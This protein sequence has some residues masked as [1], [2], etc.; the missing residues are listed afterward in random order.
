MEC[1][2]IHQRLADSLTLGA[3]HADDPEVRDH[4]EHCVACREE[5]AALERIWAGLDRIPS[6]SPDSAAMRAR[7]ASMLEGYEHGR[8][9]AHASDLAG[10]PSRA[11]RDRVN[12]W[13]ARWWPRQPLVQLA[14]AAALLVLGIAAGRAGRAPA[15]QPAED[16]ASL[17]GELRE[18]RQMLGLSLMQ[19]QSAS[20]R[21]RGVTWSSRLEEPGREVVSA[22]LDTLLHD[23]NVN[24]RLA[25]IDA[26]ARFADEQHVRQGAIDALRTADSPIVQVAL[27]D[28]VVGVREQSSVETLKRLAADPGLHDTVRTRA[29]QGLTR[30][31][32][33]S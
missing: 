30:L 21:L 4:L 1:E 27:I 14:A 29:S 5:A 33:K 23:P 2:Q 18:M 19:Q 13:L 28:F 15:E 7:F 16:L 11:R 8:D 9:G 25:A 31:G 24:V 26:L 3:E 6:P 10:A 12:A 17:R 22:L 20:D 32:A